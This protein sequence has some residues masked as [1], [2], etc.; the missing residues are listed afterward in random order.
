[1]H[2][3]RKATVKKSLKNYPRLGWMYE[4][5][6]GD[7][8]ARVCKDIPEA[9][10]QHLPRNFFAYLFANLFSKIADELSSARLI[11]PWLLGVLGAPAAFTGFLVPIREAGVLL[12]QLLVAAYIRRLPIRKTVWLLGAGLSGLCLLIMALTVVKLDGV[13]AGWIVLLLITLYSIARG[14]C[15][16]SA[17]DVLASG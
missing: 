16:V 6:T 8:D 14:L 2:E 15:S 9:S 11:L 1:M 13:A 17:K 3:T 12:P 10:C 4:Q 5:V 7:E